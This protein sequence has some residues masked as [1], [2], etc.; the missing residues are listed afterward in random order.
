MGSSEKEYESSSLISSLAYPTPLWFPGF[1]PRDEPGWAFPGSSWSKWAEWHL[2]GPFHILV[3]HPFASCQSS[4][5]SSVTLHGVVCLSWNALRHLLALPCP[6][7]G[8]AASNLPFLCLAG[9]LTGALWLPKHFPSS[10]LPV[11]CLLPYSLWFCRRGIVSG[12]W[13][14]SLRATGRSWI[15]CLFFNSIKK[16]TSKIPFS[17]FLDLGI[18]PPALN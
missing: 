10:K 5:L 17:F 4:P 16:P 13:A 7:K 2:P 14:S 12:L 11:F 18:Q 8:Q 6:T 1:C 9:L 3:L 15:M